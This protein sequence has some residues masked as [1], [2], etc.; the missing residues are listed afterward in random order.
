MS[1]TLSIITTWWLAKSRSHPA[2][3]L[4]LGTAL[5]TFTLPFIFNLRIDTDLARLLPQDLPEV[6]EME[7]LKERIGDLGY[8][9]VIVEGEDT[10]ELVHFAQIMENRLKGSPL[11]RTVVYKNPVDFVKRYRYLWI[12]AGKLTK[13]GDFLERKH[14]EQNPFCVNVDEDT[15]R[16]GSK[17]VSGDLEKYRSQLESYESMPRYHMSDDEKLL[18]I[19]VRP[20]RGVTNLDDVRRMQSYLE[21]SAETVLKEKGFSSIKKV[22]VG[23][24]L[25][26]RLDEYEI[27]L[28]D[29]VRG[30]WVSGALIILMLIMAFRNPWSVGISLL[31]LI[32]GMALT[33]FITSI[34]IGHLNTITALLFAVIFGIGIDTGIHLIARYTSLVTSGCSAQEAL[35]IVLST[36]GKAVI[37]AS[38]T[39]ALA[40]FIMTVSDFKGFSHL[41]FIAGVGILCITASYLLLF[42]AMTA[43]AEKRSLGLGPW[44]TMKTIRQRRYF[45]G[46]QSRLAVALSIALL[47]V[48]GM[49]M[50]LVSFNYDF[51]SLRGSDKS[52]KQAGET[53]GKIYT[54]T[55]TP[56]GA[57][58]AADETAARSIID[59][60]E[61]AMAQPGSVI[62]RVLSA[63]TFIPEDQE[64]R[65]EELNRISGAIT[66]RVLA[67][68]KDPDIRQELERMEQAGDLQP[69]TPGSLPP[70]VR[71]MFVMSNGEDACPV[72]IYGK[73][74]L[75]NGK[76]AIRFQSEVGHVAAEGQD[77]VPTGGAL[78]YASVI[79]KVVGQGPWILIASLVFIIFIIAI[80]LREFLKGLLALIPL[81]Q[82]LAVMVIVMAAW[83][84]ELNMYNVAILA[85]IAGLGVD[86]GVHLVTFF[87][88]LPKTLPPPQ[89]ASRSLRALF[90]PILFSWMTT[91]AGYVGLVISHHPGLRSIGTLALIG[92]AG[93]FLMSVTLLPLLLSAKL[94]PKGLT[95]LPSAAMF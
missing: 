10:D 11:V 63:Y 38:L 46:R 33:F 87:N 5:F 90:R 51:E 4:L 14:C 30:G 19:R 22:L 6:Q 95:H 34:T 60:Y 75:T 23:G 39:T 45:S 7:K 70:E 64:E 29:V 93:C 89:R 32:S 94:M 57:L 42:P 74:K 83:K 68:I 65:L 43:I 21:T 53:Q 13:I 54:K 61:K 71:E 40:F 91:S 1:S 12:P 82:G 84:I 62:D 59:T 66:P 86:Y 48:G 36:T 49:C 24:S 88:D 37:V 25:R 58:F 28:G 3:V 80:Q 8:F 69:L 72:Y 27:V 41:G 76:A 85:A 77:Y 78:I 17:E 92:L 81:F 18:A 55:L 26:G 9:S 47:A 67:S 79:E 2:A 73:E 52:S 44:I 16:V 15:A 35:R 56:G 31:P 50:T 20:A